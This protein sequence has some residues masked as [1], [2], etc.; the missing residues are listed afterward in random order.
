MRN[1]LKEIEIV[2]V[3]M[4]YQEREQC[5]WSLDWLYVNCDRVCIVLDNWDSETEAI[6]LEYKERFPDRTHVAY[7]DEP[8]IE[9]KNKI[10]GQIKKRFKIRQAQIR[11]FTLKEVRKM[12]DVK[13]IDMIIWPDSDETFINDF[14]NYLEEFWNNQ[15]AHDYLMLGCIEVFDSMQIIMRQKMAPHGRV[16]R[17]KPEMSVFPWVGRTRYNPHYN[18][19]RPWKIRHVVVHLNHL[20]EEYRERRQFFDNTDYKTRNERDLWFLPKDVREMTAV[21]IAD[22]QPGH[23]QAPP[24]YSS[25]PLEEYLDDKEHFNN[26]YNIKQYEV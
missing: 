23:R 20:T 16:Y 19:K 6:V 18:E 14:T 5:R 10:Q 17:Y 22:Y 15:P 8:F 7:S 24:K 3:V 25:I 9:E 2:G 26:K 21:E 1:Y 13:S 11:E 4:V 12:H